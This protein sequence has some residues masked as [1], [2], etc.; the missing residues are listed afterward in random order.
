MKRTPHEQ[1]IFNLRFAT[2][3]LIVAVVLMLTTFGLRLWRLLR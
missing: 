1:I 3:N 2:F